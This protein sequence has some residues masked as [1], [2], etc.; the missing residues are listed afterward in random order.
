M[1]YVSTNDLITNLKSA[2][3]NRL[4]IKNGL[5]CYKQ[6]V[7]LVN[8]RDVFNLNDLSTDVRYMGQ[9]PMPLLSKY[10]IHKY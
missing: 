4:V 10:L 7:L 9:C 6:T 8:L 5:G 1:I 3:K 2:R